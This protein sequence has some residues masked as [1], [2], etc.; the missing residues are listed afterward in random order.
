[1]NFPLDFSHSQV[2]VCSVVELPTPLTTHSQ[3]LVISLQCDDGTGMICV[4]H[5]N[6]SQ[7][8]RCIQ[9]EVVVTELAV[10]D[11]IPDGLFTCFDGVLM[12][13][14]KNGEIFVF[15]LNRASLL[16]GN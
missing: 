3:Q 2:S 13:G 12:A 8:L 5:I 7:I 11:G 4:F 10:S 16:Q 1:M 6:G 9:T 15:D 14:T